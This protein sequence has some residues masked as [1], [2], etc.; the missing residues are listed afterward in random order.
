VPLTSFGGPDVGSPRWSPDGL[1]IAFD[2]LAPGHRD[3]YIVGIEGAKPH[4]LNDDNYEN[5]RP[6]WSHD[7]KWIY[8]GSSRT[9]NWQVWKPPAAGGQPVQVTTLGGREGVESFDGT[10]FYYTK[11]FGVA[12][13]WKVPVNGGE[14][15]FVLDGVYQGF[16]G[17]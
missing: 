17:L 16:W 15:T 5:V 13:V 1:H 11:G 3:I 7:G 8:F 6:S 10:F 4:R 2:T 9:G 14:E 12:G